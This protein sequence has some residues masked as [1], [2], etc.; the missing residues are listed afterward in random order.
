MLISKFYEHERLQTTF[1]WFRACKNKKLNTINQ[2]QNQT[3]TKKVKNKRNK[4]QPPAK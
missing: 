3:P 2:K 4:K 1:H